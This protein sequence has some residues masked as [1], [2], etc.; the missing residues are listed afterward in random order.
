MELIK[1]GAS[2]EIKDNFSWDYHDY[3]DHYNNKLLEK[4]DRAS[5]LIGAIASVVMSITVVPLGLSLI[6]ATL[7]FI[8]IAVVFSYCLKD[9]D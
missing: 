9:R 1:K 2:S 5:F 6:V 3:F 4:F 8:G 7:A